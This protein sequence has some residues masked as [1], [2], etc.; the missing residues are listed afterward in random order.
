MLFTKD[1]QEEEED[2]PNYCNFILSHWYKL[3]IETG[4]TYVKQYNDLIM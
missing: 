2:I 3:Y 4:L 1:A